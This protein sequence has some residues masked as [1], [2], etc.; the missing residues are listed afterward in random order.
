M[1]GVGVCGE[2]VGQGG[3]GGDDAND[4]GNSSW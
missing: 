1:G 2:A 4:P 3:V